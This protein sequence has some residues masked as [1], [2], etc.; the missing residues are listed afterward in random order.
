ML[1]VVFLLGVGMGCFTGYIAFSIYI[2]GYLQPLESF[3]KEY[4]TI[5]SY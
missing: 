5:K 1:L 3:L 4:K 2:K